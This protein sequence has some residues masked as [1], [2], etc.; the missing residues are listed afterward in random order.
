MMSRHSRLPLLLLAA[1]TLLLLVACNA[2][3]AGTGVAT[4]DD[5]AASSSADPAASGQPTEQDRED[6]FLAFAQCMRDHGVDVPDPQFDGGDGGRVTIRGGG[7]GSGTNKIDEDAFRA[8]N[9]ACRHLIEDAVGDR[10]NVQISPED[11]Q[12]LLDYAKCMRDHGIDMPDPRFDGGGGF[13]IQGGPGGDD[14]DAKP[15]F[16][17]DSEAFQAAN[18]A[19]DDLL[20]GAFGKSGTDSS[21]GESGPGLEVKP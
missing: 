14:S 12:K 16:D 11:Q 8:A 19:C 18:D 2:A 10:G 17:L 4:I 3:D 20:P 1:A 13:V 15:R 6:A 9:E 5:P 7:P 21:S